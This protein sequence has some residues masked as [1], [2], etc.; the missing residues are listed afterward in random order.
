[1][2]ISVLPPT[3]LT[4][5]EKEEM[6]TLFSTAFQAGRA[7]FLHDL[8]EKHQVLRV[9]LHDRLAAFSTLKI[10]R[11]EERVRLLFSGDT[12]A[13]P[14][15]RVGHRLPSLWAR[16]VYQELP[17][18]PGRED[19]WLLLCS[20]FRTYRVLPTFF[21]RFVPAESNDPELLT[22]RDRWA[23]R[24]FGTRFHRGVVSPRW[25]TPLHQPAPPPHLAQDRAVQFFVKH[26]PAYREGLELVCLVPLEEKNLSR[27]G[28]RL[29]LAG[30]PS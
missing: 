14:T 15:A 13:D 18:E 24:I 19:F 26:N 27:A 4:E 21:Q 7:G 3:R 29:A 10:Y 11:P 20:G 23:G 6:F 17:P 1:M 9:H 8:K 12:Y 16:Y 30:A 25:A 22:L 2:K 28:R 5:S